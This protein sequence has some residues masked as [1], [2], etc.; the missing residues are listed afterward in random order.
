MS[1]RG[2]RGPRDQAHRIE[3]GSGDP[4][5]PT[6]RAS[7]GRGR[8]VAGNHA[9]GD[10]RR[11]GVPG[12]VRFLIFT[13]L[14]AAIVLVALF[15]A[16]R[17]LARA[18]IV[19]WAWD[20]PSAFNLPFVAGLIRE[21]LDGK[22]DAPHAGSGTQQVFDV[23]AGDTAESLATRLQAADFLSDPKAFRFAAFE[24]G[25]A[26]KLKVGSFIVRGDMSPEQLVRALVE[27]PV[28]VDSER[29][30]F[31]EGLRLEQLVAKLETVSSGVDPK[32]FY[33]LATHP[34]PA[35]LA[36]FPWLGALPEGASLE[37]FLYPATYTLIRSS[38][39][40][41]QRPTDAEGLLRMML[42]KFATTIG[43]ARMEVPKERGLDFFQVITL[44][45]IVE[46]EAVLDQERP[47]IAGVYQNRLVGYKGIAK[48]LNADP[49]VIYAVDSIELSKIGIA[50]WQNYF[51]WKVPQQKLAD[52]TV[53][54]ELA[55]YQTYRSPGLIP[56]PICS[57]SL[58]SI[59]A[60]LQPD[61][62]EGYLYFVAIPN[63]K[64]AHAFAKS[65]AEHQAN[66]KKYGY[67]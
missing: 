4:E 10:R 41:S 8:P 22:L 7:D 44:A 48:I 38:N 5:L 6:W 28:V 18:W 27:S 57:P 60:A 56:G 67:T 39:V 61:T 13:V 9:L 2:G 66:L 26:S 36:D 47:L 19:G 24:Y 35:L 32:A 21:D 46:R 45:S 64:G 40:D 37:G 33:D 23:Q 59:E 62:T 17:P 12:I 31:R 50:E 43:A 11:G 49:T 42:D 63:G 30:T 16:L 55:G 1:I 14:L 34:T 3:P 54:T 52:I 25:L 15:T 20:T 65:Y 51:F 53:P 29:V 58:A